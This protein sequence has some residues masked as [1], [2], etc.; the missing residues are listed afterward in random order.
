MEKIKKNFTT[1]PHLV[2]Q[3][4]THYA[5]T[6]VALRELIVN[7]LQA[8]ASEI[9]I[10]FERGNPDTLEPAISAITIWDNGNGLPYSEFDHSFMN[11][12]THNKKD[13][14]GIGRFAAFQLGRVMEIESVAYDPQI[15]KTTKIQV[16]IDSQELTQSLEETSVEMYLEELEVKL[17][18]YYQVR[19]TNL[20]NNEQTCE[21]RNKLGKHFES[22]EFK[23]LIFENFAFDIFE[24][25][26]RFYIDD[27]KIDRTDFLQG[28]PMKKEVPYVSVRGNE[29]T[30]TYCFYNVLLPKKDIS[31]F[32]QSSSENVYVTMRRYGYASKWHTPDLGAWFI[33]ISSDL[34]NGQSVSDFDLADLGDKESAAILA[35]IRTIIDDFF[36]VRN[37]DYDTFV[38]KL[39][40]DT[41]YPFEPSDNEIGLQESLFR[42]TVYII[43]DQSKLLEK[44]NEIRG[45]VYPMIKKLIQDGESRFIIDKVMSLPLDKKQ[46]LYELLQTADLEEIIKFSAQ[47]AS[48][49][50]FLDM[51][52]ELTYGELSKSLKER[53]QLHKIVQNEL[54]IFNEAYNGTPA[55]WSDTKLA[56]NLDELHRKYF[57]NQPTVEDENLIEEYMETMGDITDLFFYNEKPLLDGRREV[58]IVELKAPSCAISDKEISQVRR[59]AYDIHHMPVFDKTQVAYKIVLISSRMSDR[60]QSE[61]K[62]YQATFKEHGLIEHKIESGEDI[63]VY[64]FTWTEIIEKNKRALN[65]LATSLKLKEKS[66]ADIFQ[67]NFPDFIVDKGTARLIPK[68]LK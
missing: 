4:L 22:D 42:K 36:Q 45:L 25:K 68:K 48:K 23:R 29:H 14:L 46:Q 53:S 59:Y 24:E 55:L 19:I 33:Y 41:H 60:A 1:D 52:H 2:K 20:Y 30:L 63:K 43:E 3:T 37:K 39:A 27:V 44:G 49:L 11:I 56:R 47:V 61:V 54:W 35:N 34:F 58:M 31:V 67:E 6:F 16:R 7:S 51:L 8:S 17:P 66:A 62:G 5:N 50:K 28:D 40:H 64:V 21:K 13:G 57:N 26:I 32:I 18:Q 15:R 65:Y 38:A 12:G 10:S 9:K